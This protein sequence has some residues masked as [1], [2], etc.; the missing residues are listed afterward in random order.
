MSLIDIIFPKKCLGCGRFGGYVCADCFANVEFVE[1][2]ICPI[3]ER[4]AVGGK[5]HPGCQRMWGL[6]GLVVACKYKGVVRSAIQKVKYRWSFDIAEILVDFLVQSLW[7][8]DFPTYG[9]LVPIPL[10]I[11]RRRWRGFNQA[12]SLAKSLGKSFGVE[13]FD[14]LIRVRETKTQ[15]GLKK[16]ERKENVK[17]AFSIS[18]KV[19]AMKVRGRDFI[20]VDDVFTSGA[21]MNEA[22]SVLKRAGAKSVWGMA[23][24]L[25]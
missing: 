18:S 8:F 21:T 19:G 9:V 16:K 23:V 17:D 5:T 25:G 4:Q 3:C 20:L 1:A 13:V 6:D 15:V 7:R 24:A 14:I 12:E 22:A 2:P 10:H 11:K